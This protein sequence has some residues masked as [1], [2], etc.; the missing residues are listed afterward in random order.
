MF[1]AHTTI[2]Q[3]PEVAAAVVGACRIGD[4]WGSDFQPRFLG[5]LFRELVGIDLDFSNKFFG[6][7]IGFIDD[8][9]TGLFHVSLQ[10]K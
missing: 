3:A 10:L 6:I 7:T 2:T 5:L 8:E 4:S 1:L 9:I